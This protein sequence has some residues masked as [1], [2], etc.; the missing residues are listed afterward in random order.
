MRRSCS[1]PTGTCLFEHEPM[2]SMCLAAVAHKSPRLCR[3][4][5]S[6]YRGYG[7]D[8]HCCHGQNWATACDDPRGTQRATENATKAWNCH[9]RQTNINQEQLQSTPT[10][11]T[12]H[13]S[14]TGL[15]HNLNTPQS[16]PTRSRITPTSAAL[17]PLCES[18]PVRGAGG[19]SKAV[20][21]RPL[22]LSPCTT[23]RRC[24]CV[25]NNFCL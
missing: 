10:A 22:S 1:A 18:H 12:A 11:G 21:A 8:M 13:R 6:W 23:T 7:A 14:S 2:T 5:L 3:P 15:D 9:G 17:H 16:Q 25:P 24:R 4:I 19:F 20:F